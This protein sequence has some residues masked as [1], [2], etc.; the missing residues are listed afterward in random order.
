MFSYVIWY[1]GDLQKAE[2]KNNTKRPFYV[3]IGFSVMIKLTDQWQ[4]NMIE[5]L[6]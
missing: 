2:D 3:A 4:V 1:Y 6:F 5:E